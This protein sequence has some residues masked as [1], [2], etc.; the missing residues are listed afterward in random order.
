MEQCVRGGALS[1]K[2]VCVLVCLCLSI[3]L[4]DS[5]AFPCLS[6]FRPIS[7]QSFHFPGSIFTV[8]PES[9]I[10]KWGMAVSMT[11]TRELA[12]SLPR[13]LV[14]SQTYCVSIHTMKLV[15][16]LQRLSLF[17]L[18]PGTVQQHLRT[19]LIPAM[20]VSAVV[21]SA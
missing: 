8:S 12:F 18:A 3:C 1:L 11:V 14:P 21:A 5:S 16:Q 20:T 6:A 19:A 15:A 7:S 2:R 13:Y 9:R 4:M 10:W 17:S